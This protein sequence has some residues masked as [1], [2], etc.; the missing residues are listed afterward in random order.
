MYEEERGYI[1]TCPY[2]FA[3]FPQ[4]HTVFRASRGFDRSELDMDDMDAGEG[5]LGVTAKK[6]GTTDPRL[7]FQKF[8]A[9]SS[10][11]ANKKIDQKR[12]NFWKDRGGSSGYVTVDK[13]WDL[14]L[15]DPQDEASFRNMVSRDPLGGTV[16]DSDG[17]IRD[18]EGF[19]INILDKYSTTVKPATR[20]CPNCH[21]RL[22]TSDYGKYPVKFICVVGITG[23]GKTVYLNQLLTRFD[24]FVF[25]T[26]FI[27]GPHI[28]ASIGETVSPELP[29]PAATD[30]RIMRH[31]LAVTLLK[32]DENRQ[33]TDGSMTLVFYDIAGENCVN[34][35]GDPD[36][37]R[38]K[39]VIGEFIAHCDGMIFLLD[40]EQIP[41]FAGKAVKANNISNVVSVMTT[42]RQQMN[43]DLPNWTSIPVAVCLA[44][45]DKLS[46]SDQI[47]GNHPIFLRP[48]KKKEG[49][50]REENLNIS[51]FL[52]NFLHE[53]AFSVVSPLKSF[54]RKAFFA[55]SAITCGVES[56]FEKYRNQYILSEQ[57][58]SRFHIL[59]RWVKGWNERTKEEREH[60]LNCSVTQLD[61]SPIQIDPAQD[62]TE[63]N[64]KNI[65]TQICANSEQGTSEQLSLWD[66]AHEINLVGYPVSD[67]NP[68]RIGD[69]LK[70]ILWKLRIIEP[71]FIPEPIGEKPFWMSNK[72]W[73]QHV[74]EVNA[75]NEINEKLWYG[76]DLEEQ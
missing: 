8:D 31:P 28:L 12:V 55:V 63:S 21:N 6:K 67:P 23:S 71:Y 39:A 7:L 26:D 30:D 19:I 76:E 2:C 56:R 25:G 32:L 75:R 9:E 51:E 61:G 74:A 42:I 41:T 53:N 68:R 59:R 46:K 22:P 60:Y 62:I 29:L 47:P 48:D 20:L 18:S 13:D 10:N 4:E 50:D 66:V 69:P 5:L 57:D 36:E 1:I 27:V 73:Q 72:K 52:K 44:K 35:D 58:D 33:E 15:I 49:F 65:I 3:E 16:P 24:E 17:F 43:F 37:A 45:S 14:P 64:A 70:W 54:P 38:A 11:V 34:K 40:P